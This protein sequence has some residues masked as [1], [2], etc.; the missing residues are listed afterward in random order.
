M[1][2][3]GDAHVV[4]GIDRAPEAEAAAQLGGL[5]AEDVP[6]HVRRDEDVERPRVAD[7]PGGPASTMSSRSSTSG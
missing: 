5:V 2:G 7:E 4:A 3:L 6:E 1:L